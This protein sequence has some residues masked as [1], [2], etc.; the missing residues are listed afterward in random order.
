MSYTLANSGHI[1]LKAGA[2]VS[3]NFTGTNAEANLTQF[4]DEGEASANALA[5]IDLVASY[6]SMNANDKKILQSFVSAWAGSRAISY[7]ASGYSSPQEVALMLNVLDEE[8]SF[9]A[10][11]IK[12][13]NWT[14]Y[15]GA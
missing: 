14:S 8:I 2:N 5:R 1:L 10:D 9:G 15:A 12:D 3:S 7:D 4:A 13:K 11:F 6:S